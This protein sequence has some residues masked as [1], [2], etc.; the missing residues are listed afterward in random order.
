MI[1]K[2]QYIVIAILSLYSIFTTYKIISDKPK[3]I[4]NT[5]TIPGDIIYKDTIVYQPKPYKV[6]IPIHD[7]TYIPT[8]SAQCVADYKK[9]Y[10]RFSSTNYYK[11]TLRND[12][13]MTVVV[14]SSI[15]NNILQDIQLRSKNNRPISISN[16]IVT[17]KNKLPMLSVGGLYDMKSL[18]IYGELRVNPNL[19]LNAGY[20]LSI[21]SPVVGIKYTIFSK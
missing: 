3:V 5:V 9:L 13:S 20:N 18:T 15:S 21:K 16:T 4:T 1:I 17:Y 2:T 14:N 11:D 12:T 6:E 7:T 10:K 19:Y 8:D